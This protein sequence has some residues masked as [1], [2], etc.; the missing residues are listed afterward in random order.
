MLADDVT[1][2]DAPLAG[3]AMVRS[4][5][6]H[7]KLCRDAAERFGASEDVMTPVRWRR[8]KVG[9]QADRADFSDEAAPLAALF[10][11]DQHEEEGV[12]CKPLNGVEKFTALRE[13]TYG[14]DGMGPLF[15]QSRVAM[16]VAATVPI[17][18]LLRPRT[19]W[20]LDRVV[21]QVKQQVMGVAV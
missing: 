3:T 10:L 14:P 13:H 1:V 8:R 6:P 15:S 7:Y 11:L 4:G 12:L 19:G 5:F 2:I 9:I 20:T 21:A 18:R 17:F 16:Q